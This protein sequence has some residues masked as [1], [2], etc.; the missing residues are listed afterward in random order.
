MDIKATTTNSYGF[1][2]AARFDGRLLYLDFWGSGGTK[3]S[4]LMYREHSVTVPPE[5]AEEVR[6]FIEH[7]NDQEDQGGSG[8]HDLEHMYAV[9]LHGR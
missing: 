7:A 2:R 5:R 8:W 9:I 3:D 1:T 6:Q 4:G